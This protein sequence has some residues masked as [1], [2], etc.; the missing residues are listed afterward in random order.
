MTW[1]NELGG[2]KHLGPAA[3]EE[4]S[5]ACAEAD[6][7]TCTQIESLHVAGTR[8]VFTCIIIQSAFVIIAWAN[9]ALR[10]VLSWA[11]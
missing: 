11:C 5:A 3:Q 10:R 7:C 1:R 9:P 2:E 4:Q 6:A 8:R